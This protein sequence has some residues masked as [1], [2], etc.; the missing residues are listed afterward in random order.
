MR[1]KAELLIATINALCRVVNQYLMMSHTRYRSAIDDFNS[2]I[3]PL[4]IKSKI[5]HEI[6]W[7]NFI[8]VRPKMK[9]KT[10]TNTKHKE[11][12]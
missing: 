11:I 7:L 6:E 5:K 3:N 12:F 9:T 1:P 2:L 10:A 4:I 8:Q